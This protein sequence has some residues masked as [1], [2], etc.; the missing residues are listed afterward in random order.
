MRLLSSKGQA[1]FAADKRTTAAY[2]PPIGYRAAESQSRPDQCHARQTISSPHPRPDQAPTHRREQYAVRQSLSWRVSSP[3]SNL[4]KFRRV[5]RSSKLF[6]AGNRQSSTNQSPFITKQTE[7]NLRPHHSHHDRQS[8]RL[9]CRE[10][11][12]AFRHLTKEHPVCWQDPRRP[13]EEY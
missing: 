12:R 3:P 5:F 11:M 2:T 8:G 6:L 9:G 1:D 7:T 13:F 10:D 4:D